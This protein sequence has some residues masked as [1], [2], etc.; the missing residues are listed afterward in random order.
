MLLD[1][2]FGLPNDAIP[3]VLELLGGEPSLDDLLDDPFQPKSRDGGPPFSVGRY[4]TGEWAVFYAAEDLETAYR[5]WGHHHLRFALGDPA[6]KRVVYYT[7]YRIAFDGSLIDLGTKLADWPELV[8]EDYAFCQSLA[9]EGR[10]LPIETFDAPSARRPGFG[11]TPVFDR[12]ALSSPVRE[13]LSAFQY[14]D[15]LEG[16]C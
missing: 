2:S 3:E 15:T 6:A 9:A 14:D 5:E 1:P 10:Q 11:T 16:F 12:E 4:S 8:S 13:Q 7:A